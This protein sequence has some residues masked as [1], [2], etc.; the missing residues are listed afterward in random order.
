MSSLCHIYKNDKH[1]LPECAQ[2]ESLETAS[3]KI[4]SVKTDE[5]Q[6]LAVLWGRDGEY[7]KKM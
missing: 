2:L 3:L 1:K 4:S 6:V 7:S 5:L